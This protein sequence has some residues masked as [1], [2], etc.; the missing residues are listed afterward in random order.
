MEDL[1]SAATLTLAAVD[2]PN[3]VCGHPQPFGQTKGSIIYT[4]PTTYIG[5]SNTTSQ[6]LAFSKR[7][8][9][10]PFVCRKVGMTEREVGFRVDS[11]RIRV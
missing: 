8:R 6:S 5:S 2:V 3:C 4:G 9:P 10:E 1:S 7:C 11:T